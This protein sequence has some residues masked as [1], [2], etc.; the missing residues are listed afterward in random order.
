MTTRTVSTP[1]YSPM[2]AAQLYGCHSRT[3]KRW[4]REGKMFEAY[5]LPSGHWKIVKASFDVF[6]VSNNRVVRSVR[7]RKTLM[8]AHPD[9]EFIRR[10][11]MRYDNALTY[12]VVQDGSEALLRIGMQ[13]PDLV[14][15]G[16]NVDAESV[17]RICAL[18]QSY[19]ALELVKV[20]LYR[21]QPCEKLQERWRDYDCVDMAYFTSEWEGEGAAEKELLAFIDRA[22]TPKKTPSTT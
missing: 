17:L 6:L 4:A 12:E 18:I 10:I 3:I 14:V 16:D 19:L 5:M 22:I 8:L 9:E 21:D 20:V 7:K 1:T 13:V 11:R 15:L 2:Q